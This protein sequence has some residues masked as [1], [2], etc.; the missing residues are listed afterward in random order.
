VLSYNCGYSKEEIEILNGKSIDLFLFVRHLLQRRMS[1]NKLGSALVGAKKTLDSGLEGIAL[2]KKYKDEGDEKAY[3][4][5]K[6]YCKNDVTM[7]HLILLYFLKY[8]K[9]S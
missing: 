4:Q 9:L 2:R 3:T 8:Q 6:K 1:L 5:F 7:T